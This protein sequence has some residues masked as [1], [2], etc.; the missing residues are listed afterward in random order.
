MSTP[1]SISASDGAIHFEGRSFVLGAGASKD[2][3]IS[4]LADLYAGSRNH[5]NGYEW[6][7]F[8]GFSFGGAP[9][10]MSLCFKFGELVEA[11]W[12]VNL[13][14]AEA[15]GGWPTK[16]A[17]DQ[18]VEFVCSVLAKAFA[19]QHFSGHR[20]FSWG[21]VWSSFDPKGFMASSGLRY[22]AQQA[23]PPDVPAAASRRQGRG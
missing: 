6:A 20:V 4:G 1:F 11:H 3:A 8:K 18:E 22:K 14:G 16:N 7:F 21:E 13:P 5:N 2:A 19:P 10:G 9:S 12:S 15:E 17:I 23:V